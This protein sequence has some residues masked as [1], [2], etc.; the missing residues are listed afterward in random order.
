M[1]LRGPYIGEEGEGRANRNTW[2]V[3]SKGMLQRNI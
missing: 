3:V 2:E 1:K